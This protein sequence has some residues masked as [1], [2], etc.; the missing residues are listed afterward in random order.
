MKETYQTRTQMVMENL[1]TRILSG[2]LPAGAPLRQDALARELKVSRI[3]V[4]EALMQLEAQGLVKFTAH[5][6]AVVTA[7]DSSTI[8]ELFYLRALLEADTLF[9]AVDLMTE[10][11]FV[12]AEAILAEFDRA[13]ESGTQ[14]ERWAELNHRFHA[15]LYRAAGRPQAMEL[16]DQINLSCDRYVRVEL[17]FAH[18]GVDKAEREHAQLLTLCRARRKHEAVVLLQQ[19]IAE[20]AASVK[21]ILQAG[22]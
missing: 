7:L 12:D 18:D 8:D 10:A 16:I 11:T 4:R 21:R 19:H 14:V 15:T 2:E 13:L 5:R 9:H 1:R 17:L 20:A 6:G 3:P 22:A